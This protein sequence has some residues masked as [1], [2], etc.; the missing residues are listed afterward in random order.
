MNFYDAL[1]ARF[2]KSSNVNT[3]EQIVR[4][5]RLGLGP[6]LYPV[7]SELTT[8]KAT[9]ITAECEADNTGV[10]EASVDFADFLGGVGSARSGQYVFLYNGVA[11]TLDNKTVSLADYG[12]TIVDGSP[13]SGDAIIVTETTYPITFRVVGHDHFEAA[14]PALTHTMALESKYVYSDAAGTYKGL[15]FDA[16]ETLFYCTEGLEAGTY[17]FTWNY[18]TGSMVNGTY[19]FTLTQNVPTGGQIVMGTNS[20]STA[21]TACKISTFA[22]VGATEAIESNIAIT[23]GFDGISLGTIGATSSSAENLNCAQRIIWG[24]NNYAQSGARQWFNSDAALHEVWA[25][26][27]KYDRPPTWHTGN[28]TYYAGFMHGLGADFLGAVKTAKIPCRTNNVN[29]IESLDGTEYSTGT[30]YTVENKFF[31]LSRPEI[32]GTWDSESVKDGSQLAYYDG[33][34]Q[35]DLIKRGGGGTARRAW[36]RSPN[37]SSASAER[38]VNTDGSLNEGNVAVNAYAVAPACIIA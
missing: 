15:V 7:G 16:P 18:A 11:W 34:T 20:N 27:T 1:F 22:T 30:V 9:S 3:W 13:V 35:S 12:V 26:K 17:N 38:I 5:V 21:I 19:Q 6:Q 10:T 28:N 4:D 31:V 29:E 14:D 33:L 2:L 23:E 32:Y 24:S 37:P 8:E 25:P 36:L